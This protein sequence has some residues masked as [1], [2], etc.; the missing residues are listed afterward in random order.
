MLN[1]L[2]RVTSAAALTSVLLLLA[3]CAGGSVTPNA[4]GS[5]QS[6]PLGVQHIAGQNRVA[7]AA[8]DRVTAIGVHPNTCPKRFPD[9]CYVVSLT[10]GASIIWC[11]GPPSAPCADTDLHGWGGVVTTAKDQ[12]TTKMSAYWTGPFP[13]TVSECPGDPSGTY[14][15]DNITPGPRLRQT[16]KFHYVESVCED[17]SCVWP[18]IGL[19]V[20]P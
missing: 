3:A 16:D 6:T 9:G 20:G 2:S 7:I 8:R 15:L 1:G 13:C 18:A 5:T 4:A 12:P 19:L 10:N 11:Y 17:A 14:V